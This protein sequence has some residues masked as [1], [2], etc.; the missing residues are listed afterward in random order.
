M[1]KELLVLSFGTGLLTIN[2]DAVEIKSIE[3]KTIDSSPVL[4][5]LQGS[6]LTVDTG[7]QYIQIKDTTDKIWSIR[8]EPATRILDTD[9]RAIKASELKEKGRVRVYYNTRDNVARQIDVVPT[10]AEEA[11]GK[12]K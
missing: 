1:K 5:E 3:A 6:V 4:G 8:L 10:P 11:L 7:G 9:N 12:T 2:L